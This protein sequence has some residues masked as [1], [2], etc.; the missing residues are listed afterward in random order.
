MYGNIWE[1]NTDI[2]LKQGHNGALFQ[3]TRGTW[4]ATISHEMHNADTFDTSRVCK[5][6]SAAPLWLWSQRQE[7]EPGLLV[8]TYRTYE[9]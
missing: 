9:V 8:T 5:A 4:S 3:G 7:F 6:E 2:L 1:N